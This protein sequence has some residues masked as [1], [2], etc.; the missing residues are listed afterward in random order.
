MY[1]VF[2]ILRHF[3]FFEEK[4][5]F[6]KRKLRETHS[7]SQTVFLNCRFGLG[8]L[9]FHLGKIIEEVRLLL[10]LEFFEKI[11]HF[12]KTRTREPK[13]SIY[14][15]LYSAVFGTEFR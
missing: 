1:A 12:R 14:I 15:K 6:S 9:R 5:G 13:I 10:E 8:R 3:Q 2:Q 11:D 7:W 4:G